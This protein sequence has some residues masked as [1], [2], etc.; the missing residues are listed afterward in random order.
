MLTSGFSISIIKS[1]QNA[2]KQQ[3]Q[4][5]L[6]NAALLGNPNAQLLL[7]ET[8]FETAESP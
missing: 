1:Y 3:A 6:E 5:Y 2:H 8:R 7:A 4:Q